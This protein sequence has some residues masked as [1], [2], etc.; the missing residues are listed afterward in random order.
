MTWMPFI[1]VNDGSVRFT[2][3]KP[4]AEEAEEQRPQLPN[5]GDD[6][7]QH[8]LNWI[9]CIRSR[10]QPPS[11]VDWHLKVMVIVD[12]ATRSLWEGGAW[13]FD[14]KTLTAKRT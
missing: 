10:V 6:Q 9:T 5:I 4:Y 12:L 7:D 1:E 2:P 3:Q 8:R 11:N 14:P 13:A